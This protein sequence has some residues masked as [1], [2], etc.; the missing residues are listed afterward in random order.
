MRETFR[1]GDLA[2]VV[3]TCCAGSFG[4]TGGRIAPVAG[5]GR[6]GTRCLHCQAKNVGLH[7]GSAM[8]RPGVPVLWLKR[9]D[10]HPDLERVH[11]QDE[12]IIP[13]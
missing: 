5:I 9:I 10:R 3:R 1:I 12:A 13:A 11:E 7:A 6:K 8:D 2:C 4:E